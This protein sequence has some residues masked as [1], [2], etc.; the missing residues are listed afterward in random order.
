MGNQH[1]TP[2]SPEEVLAEKKE[3]VINAV[4]LML[5]WQKSEKIKKALLPQLDSL[6]SEEI[7]YCLRQVR[8]L[9]NQTQLR[10]PLSS[11]AS[12]AL[13]EDEAKL[14]EMEKIIGSERAKALKSL[15]E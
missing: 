15:M 6:T 7:D 4:D 10:G 14:S 3:E 13:T 9:D 11:T 1:E 8:Y 5:D 12:E 2:S